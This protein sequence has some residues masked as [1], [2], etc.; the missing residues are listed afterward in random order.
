MTRTTKG[1]L[2]TKRQR[3]ATSLRNT[4]TVGQ[5]V[6]R[7]FVKDDKS[8]WFEGEVVQADEYKFKVHFDDGDEKEYEQSDVQ[9]D[10]DFE[11]IV[12]DEGSAVDNP[13]PQRQRLTPSSRQSY[14]CSER[15]VIE[16]AQAAQLPVGVQR[17]NSSDT[18][19]TSAHSVRSA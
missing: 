2:Y 15:L 11:I 8:Q 5:R 4:V 6:R 18:A 17:S 12:H 1:Q 3:E 10:P 14:T 19:S 7:L 13:R 9:D 16:T